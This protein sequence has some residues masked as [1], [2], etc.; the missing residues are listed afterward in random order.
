ML[1]YISEVSRL[2]K[3]GG[4]GLVTFFLLNPE[5]ESLI[6]AGKSRPSLVYEAEHGSKAEKPDLLEFAIGHQEEFVVQ[7]FRRYGMRMQVMEYG[8]WCGRING[9]YYQDFVQ[10]KRV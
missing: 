3:P 6:A 4:G 9:R 5:S 7:A 2:L 8:A 10:I 1:H